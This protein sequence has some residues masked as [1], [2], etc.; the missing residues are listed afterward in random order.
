VNTLNKQSQ[1]ADK[2]RYSSLGSGRGSNT[3]ENVPCYELFHKAA[4]LD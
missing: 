4:D 3:V 1:T 2:V